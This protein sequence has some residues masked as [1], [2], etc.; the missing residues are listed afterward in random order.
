M[1]WQWYCLAAPCRSA[2]SIGNLPALVLE[3]SMVAI[4]FPLFLCD[5]TWSYSVFPRLTFI[6]LGIFAGNL[7]GDTHKYNPK[8]HRNQMKWYMSGYYINMCIYV[9]MSVTILLENNWIRFEDILSIRKIS[10]QRRILYFL[11]I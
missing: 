2:S 7:H 3:R 9:Q 4:F 8:F 11:D 6:P 5:Y 10:L 1:N